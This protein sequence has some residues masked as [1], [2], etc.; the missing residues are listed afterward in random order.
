MF[1]FAATFAC[2]AVATVA[3]VL[4]VVAPLFTYRYYLN[5]VRMTVGQVPAAFPVDRDGRRFGRDL[6]GA[7][8]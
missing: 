5:S 8:I 4:L 7:L 1:K 2:L 3:A 6:L